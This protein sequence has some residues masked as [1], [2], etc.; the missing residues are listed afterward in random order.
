MDIRGA[1]F[2]IWTGHHDV[3]DCDTRKKCAHQK[4][5]GREGQINFKLS[6]FPGEG[7]WRAAFREEPGIEAAAGRADAM[8]KVEAEA[9]RTRHIASATSPQ[10]LAI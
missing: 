5:W 4:T 6:S 7:H 9:A 3:G 1:G 10:P 8:K 2:H